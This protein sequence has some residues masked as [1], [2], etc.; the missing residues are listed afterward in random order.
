MLCKKFEEKIVDLIFSEVGEEEE[1]QL[2][3][4]IKECEKCRNRYNEI[5]MIIEESKKIEVPVFAPE[6]WDEKRKVI[7]EQLPDNRKNFRIKKKVVFSLVLLLFIFSLSIFFFINHNENIAKK[8]GTNYYTFNTLSS[9]T[10]SS[11]DSILPFS[12]DEILKMADYMKD[13]D[14]EEVLKIILR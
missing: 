3:S 10:F 14:A 2:L 11:P 5:K 7:M 4:H 8:E 6:W 9:P 13:S 1:K 12:E